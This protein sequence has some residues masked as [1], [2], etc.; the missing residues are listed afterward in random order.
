MDAPTVATGVILSILAGI[1]PTAIYA[2]VLWWFD[3]YEKEPWSLLSMA[4]LWGAIPAVIISL[5]A[6]NVFGL[7]RRSN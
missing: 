4:F 6:E 2:F 5:I 7:T 3:R 1:V